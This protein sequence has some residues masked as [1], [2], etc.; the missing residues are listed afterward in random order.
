ME[1]SA[2]VGKIDYKKQQSKIRKARRKGAKKAAAKS[3]G[4]LLNTELRPS[5]E[6][7]FFDNADPIQVEHFDTS[8]YPAAS[9]GYVGLGGKKMNNSKKPIKFERID[10]QPGM[11]QHVGFFKKIAILQHSFLQKKAYSDSRLQ[12]VCDHSPCSTAPG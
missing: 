4:K 3:S 9:T 11:A 10:K 1:S 12:N 6:K 8:N 7:R 2:S 5:V